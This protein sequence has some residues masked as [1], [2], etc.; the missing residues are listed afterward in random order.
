MKLVMRQNQSTL[1]DEKKLQFVNA[2]R[3]LKANGTYDRYV[4]MHWDNVYAGHR[5]PAFL[6][7]HREFLRRF[8][9][10]LQNAAQDPLLGLPYWDWSVKVPK[11]RR[12]GSQV[13]WVKRSDLGRPSRERAVCI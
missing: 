1:Y 4:K 13:S 8:E 6:P 12:S 5:G 11:P 7:W 10:D 9:R 2:V 3:A